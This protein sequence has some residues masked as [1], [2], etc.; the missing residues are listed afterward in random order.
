MT[1]PSKLL[2]SKESK[3]PRGRKGGRTPL[4]EAEKRELAQFYLPR[5]LLAA[6]K[7]LIPVAAD[8][9]NLVTKWVRAYAISNGESDRLLAQSPIA[10][11][12]LEYLEATSAPQE[13]IDKLESLIV[14]RASDE[15]RIDKGVTKAGNSWIV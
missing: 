14:T 8:R 3:T 4:P 1:K 9:S 13:L 11:E 10:S 7:E 15:E 2:T 12:V 5:W 6:F